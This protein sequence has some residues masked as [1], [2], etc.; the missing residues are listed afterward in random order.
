MRNSI[1]VKGEWLDGTVFEIKGDTY[2]GTEVAIIVIRRDL[3]DIHINPLA[4]RF[5]MI[6]TQ[7]R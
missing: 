2:R 5:F 7:A 4:T 6:E 1:T 3:P